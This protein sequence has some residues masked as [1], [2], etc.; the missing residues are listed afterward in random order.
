MERTRA[1]RRGGFTLVE[2]AI[3]IAI[4]ALLAIPV[5]TLMSQL[6]RNQIYGAEDIKG[7]YAVNVVM[8]DIEQRIRR[9]D[10]GS[11][12]VNAGTVSFAYT[13]TDNSGNQ[14][15]AVAYAY[16][17]VDSNTSTS[18]FYR[19]RNADPRQVFPAGLEP[20]IIRSFSAT[21]TSTSPYSI[22]IALVSS[23]GVS[24]RKDIYLANYAQ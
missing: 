19:K 13:D 9:A 23:T 2:E 11:I 17:L 5:A 7:Q 22:T 10:D 15:N 4:V 24:L 21:L 3:V 20:G 6:F 1:Y 14:T 12:A 8:Q 18:L 16:E